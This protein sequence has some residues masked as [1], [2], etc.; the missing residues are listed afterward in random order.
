MAYNVQ[1]PLPVLRQLDMERDA[2]VPAAP[3]ARPQAGRQ[4]GR[5]EQILTVHPLCAWSWAGGNLN[6]HD[7]SPCGIYSS[8]VGG[9]VKIDV[10][11]GLGRGQD[12]H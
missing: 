2:L 11:K 1:I 9:R 6:R 7:A 10:E 8:G 5:Q 3:K 4:V 12:A